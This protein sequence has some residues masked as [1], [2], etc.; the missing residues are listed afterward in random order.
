MPVDI[1]AAGALGAGAVEFLPLYYY[2][3]SLAGPPEGADWAT[4][5]FE[6]PAFRKVFKASLQAVKKAGVPVDF[7]LGANQGQGV[8]AETTDPGLH[9]D[10][11]PY[12]LEVP[13]NGSYSGQIPGWGTGKLVVLVSARVISSS[14]IKTPAS[15][16]FSTSAHNATQLV[17]QGDTLIEHTNKV[18]AD[19]TVFVSLRNGT[20]NANKYIRSNSQHYLFAYYQYQDLAK[21]LDIESNTT[22]TIFD[23]G[24]Y[25]VDHY[26]AR[27]AEATKG[28]WETYILNDIEIRSL[29][30]EVGTYGWE[31]SLEIK[32]NISWSPSLPERFE[33]MHGYRL[34]KYLPLLMYENN[35]PVVQPSYPGSIKCALEEQHHGN[36]FVNDFRAALS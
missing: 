12:H 22:G 9:W 7:A 11:A 4:Y 31:D 2:G 17:L 20:A 1:E 33:K 14:Q 5:G 15:S 32:S 13:E 16:T 27:G 29:L 26:S 21:N 28:F 25:T 3:E 35:Y 23:N 36:G 8:P 24:S 6:T 18:N 34:H 19:G 30:T 10:L